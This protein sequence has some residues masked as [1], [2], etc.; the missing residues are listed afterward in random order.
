MLPQTW[1]ALE[2]EERKLVEDNRAMYELG[3][4]W[5]VAAPTQLILT[6]PLREADQTQL[7]PLL[8]DLDYLDA[9]W[10]KWRALGGEKKKYFTSSLRSI[11]TD[12]M[13]AIEY[14]TPEHST[15]ENS[16]LCKPLV[17]AGG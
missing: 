10:Q 13:A 8:S 5:V 7:Q 15:L 14:D 3:A 4:G 11:A 9:E 17:K 6:V 16:P 12:A 2:S 1:E